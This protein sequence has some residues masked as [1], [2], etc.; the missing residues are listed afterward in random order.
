MYFG[1]TEIKGAAAL[2]GALQVLMIKRTCVPDLGPFI[3]GYVPHSFIPL[4]VA[5]AAPIPLTDGPYE[6]VLVTR[7]QE[8]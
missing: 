4:F 1:C 5:S 8:K 3:Q 7:Q 6:I 2:A